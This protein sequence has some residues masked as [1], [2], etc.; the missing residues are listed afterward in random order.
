MA[1]S[2]YDFSG[3]IFNVLI[4]EADNQYLAHCLELDIVTVSKTE[5][6]VKRDI[7]DLIKTQV[8]YAFSNDNLDYLYHPAPP[9]LWQEFY[10]CKKQIEKKKIKIEKKKVKIEPT[11]RKSP[12]HFVPPWIIAST[13]VSTAQTCYAY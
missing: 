13:C 6:R 3:M 11:L 4:K 1:F 8:E 7:I 9:E 12:Q 5:S 2:K 10:E